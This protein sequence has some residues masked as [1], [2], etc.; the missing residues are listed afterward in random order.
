MTPPATTPAGRRRATRRA[1]GAPAAPRRV[2]GPLGGRV[3]PTAGSATA[4]AT[5]A[6]ATAGA[7]TAGAATVTGRTTFTP[8]PT[9]RQQTAPRRRRASPG[10]RGRA[11]SVGSRGR[12]AAVGGRALALVRGLPDH[13]LLDRAIRG[14]AWIPILGVMLAGIVAMQVE[15]LKLGAS[16]GRSIQRGTALQSR[17]DLLRASV[18][19][20]A[21]DQRIE[22][23]AAGMGMVMPA[24]A[25]VGFLPRGPSDAAR[26]ARSIHQPDATAFLT[27][28]AALSATGTP[29]PP[30]TATTPSGSVSGGPAVS[31]AGPS[32]A[33]QTTGAPAQTTTPTQPTTVAPTQP[34]AAVQ[35]S[36]S[37]STSGGALATGG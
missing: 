28:L 12:A 3:R 20:L 27:S 10:S 24:P 35:P 4:A 9:R 34:V 14:R 16:M 19:S 30:G 32:V 29:V 7:A 11:A 25:E 21:D 26:A 33:L 22:R 17:N 2:S 1:T 23:L 15:V 8:R 31:S 37:S 6:T 13:A 5:A 18:A 36:Q